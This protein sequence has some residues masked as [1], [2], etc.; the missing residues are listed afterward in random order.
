MS[1][2]QPFVGLISPN[3]IN[4]QGLGMLV[5]LE[6]SP[7]PWT[8]AAPS[9]KILKTPPREFLL[10]SEGALQGWRSPSTR[11]PGILRRAVRFV[12]SWARP[13]AVY[14]L[15]H[16]AHKLLPKKKRRRILATISQSGLTTH[17]HHVD[18]L[19]LYYVVCQSVGFKLAKTS[20][21]VSKAHLLNKTLSAR[22]VDVVH[23]AEI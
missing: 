18:S 21:R 11:L 23:K 10:D 4:L 13:A 6:M 5:W 14:Q 17:D 22:K 7:R 1:F 8:S 3:T 2:L 20:S 15:Q 12:E 9:H 16:L 19:R